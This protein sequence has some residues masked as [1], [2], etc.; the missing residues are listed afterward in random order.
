MTPDPNEF[1]MEPMMKVNILLPEIG[2]R[3]LLEIDLLPTPDPSLV[4]GF[5]YVFGVRED[6]D[7]YAHFA[8]GL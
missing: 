1:G 3:F 6:C 4:D 7:G 2:V 5:C 8:D